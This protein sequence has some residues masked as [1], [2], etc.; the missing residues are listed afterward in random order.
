MSYG[1]LAGVYDRLMEDAP[2][3]EWKRFFLN[4]LDR[5]NIRAAR[6]L[7]LGCGTGEITHR[8]AGEGFRMTGVDLSEEMLAVASS[9]KA[10]S[11]QWMQQDITRLEGFSGYDAVISFCDVVNYVTDEGALESMFHRASLAL[12][13]NGLF[14]FDIHAPSYALEVLA[15]ETFAEV[16]D[17]LSYIWFCDMD[18]DIMTHDLTF[19]VEQNG[20]YQRFDEEHHQR[21]YEPGF[22][23]QLLQKN[24]FHTLSVHSD[25]KMEHGSEGD[26]IFFVGQKV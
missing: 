15:G 1:H 12:E 25:F 3:E 9:K 14:M 2:Y 16:Y 13:E 11:V 23:N 19:F 4:I 22:I 10:S 5:E 8:L 20:G 18:E 24:G 17:D 6:V 26:R 21:I 7:E